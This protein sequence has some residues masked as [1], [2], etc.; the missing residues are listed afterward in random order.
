MRCVSGDVK[1]GE[2]KKRRK[3]KFWKAAFASLTHARDCFCS[4]RTQLKNAVSFARSFAAKTS[5]K[6]RRMS[7]VGDCGK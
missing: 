2:G 7:A 3:R 4:T 5:Q 6:R 1:W